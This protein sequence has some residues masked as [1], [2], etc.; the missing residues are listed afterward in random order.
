MNAKN[1][2][3]A[4]ALALSTLGANTASASEMTPASREYFRGL[5]DLA[6]MAAWRGDGRAA[7]ATCDIYRSQIWPD[8]AA[9][10]VSLTLQIHCRISVVNIYIHHTNPLPYPI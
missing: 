1:L 9:N 7:Q 6:M 3:L 8:P 10:E 4:S 5:W 2:I